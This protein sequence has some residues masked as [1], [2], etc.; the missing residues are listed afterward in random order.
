MLQNIQQIQQN[1]ANMVP[2]AIGKIPLISVNIRTSIVSTISL[3]PTACI[4][5]C[6]PLSVDDILI[7]GKDPTSKE[8]TI[9]AEY[10]MSK[11]IIVEQLNILEQLFSN[12]SGQTALA[13]QPVDDELKPSTPV[14]KPKI[15]IQ[16]QSK[17]NVDDNTPVSSPLLA[18]KITAAA[19]KQSLSD[20]L[21]KVK[22]D[23]DQN[24]GAST[25]R[26]VAVS[27]SPSTHRPS[28][29]SRPPPKNIHDYINVV[30]P[31]GNMAKKLE[32]AA[33]YNFFLTTITA[34][35]PTHN[36]PLSITFQG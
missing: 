17:G 32:N 35:K 6:V 29:D 16:P 7:A 27:A 31:K 13:P 4:L 12:R 22:A 25:S 11:D 15:D 9:P 30:V 14:K 21:Q 36:E 8:Y 10:F 23:R 24:D 5:S 20:T 28:N 18:K 3:N 33:P 2:N 1:S 34:S 26:Q 19:L